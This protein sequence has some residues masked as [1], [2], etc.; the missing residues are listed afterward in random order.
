MICCNNWSRVAIAQA[1]KEIELIQEHIV[2]AFH[3][4]EIR[5]YTEFAVQ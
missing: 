5:P 1:E 3:P 4:P 2:L